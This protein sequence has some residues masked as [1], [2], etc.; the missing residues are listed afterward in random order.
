MNPTIFLVTFGALTCVLGRE[1]YH[2]LW[3]LGFIGIG[4]WSGGHLPSGVL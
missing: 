1:W 3:G 2:A 4:L